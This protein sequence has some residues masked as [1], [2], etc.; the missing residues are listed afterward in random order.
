MTDAGC[1]INCTRS[2]FPYE[3]IVNRYECDCIPGYYR[4][5][6]NGECIKQCDQYGDSLLFSCPED[7]ESCCCPAF[8]TYY[9]EKSAGQEDHTECNGTDYEGFF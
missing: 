8:Y 1:Q 6:D 7:V 5:G 9:A 4:G 3:M 2:G